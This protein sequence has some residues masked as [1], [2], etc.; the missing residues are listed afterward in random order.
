[1][2]SNTTDYYPADLVLLDTHL[3]GRKKKEKTDSPADDLDR[4]IHTLFV[5]DLY[6][7]NI[8]WESD[9]DV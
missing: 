8:P 3:D 1:M 4:I 9:R 7:W 2:L 5:L 6:S